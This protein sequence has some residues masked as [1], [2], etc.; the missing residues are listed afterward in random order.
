MFGDDTKTID[1]A[2]HAYLG[3]G[4]SGNHCDVATLIHV[5]HLNCYSPKDQFI[6]LSRISN[7]HKHG[8]PSMEKPS[9]IIHP[10]HVTFAEHV[11]YDPFAQ[12]N[13]EGYLHKELHSSIT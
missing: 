13:E 2:F 8:Y 6:L 3:N 7:N 12:E 10:K 9:N 1:M 11:L 5:S 4:D